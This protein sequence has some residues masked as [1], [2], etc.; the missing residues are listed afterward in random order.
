MTNGFGWMSRRA[1]L[2]GGAAVAV[3]G[4]APPLLARSALAARRSP[5]TRSRF[6]PALGATLR[7]T[8]GG[9]DVDVVLTDI[10]DLLPTLRADDPNR[11]MLLLDA[12]RTHRPASGMRTLHHR[13]IG[14]VALFVSPVDRGAKAVRYAAVINRS[15]S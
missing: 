14:H 9:H 1:F 3:L 8:G 12:P 5:L 6:A 7:M 4:V 15:R 13:D 10:A 11:F 2:R